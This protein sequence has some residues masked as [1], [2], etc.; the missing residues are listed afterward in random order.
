MN[1]SM[2]VSWQSVGLTIL[3]AVALLGWK[4]LNPVIRDLALSCG[5]TFL[6]YVFF[7]LDQGQG[8]GYRYIYSVQGNLALLAVAGFEQLKQSVSSTRLL[9]WS[10]PFQLPRAR[11]PVSDSLSANR[12]VCQAVCE[13]NGLHPLAQTAVRAGRPLDG[14]VCQRPGPQ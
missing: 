14:L 2:V 6:F 3:A 8:F 4:N 10:D 1:L 13:F 11:N 7:N 12:E 5:L 9:R